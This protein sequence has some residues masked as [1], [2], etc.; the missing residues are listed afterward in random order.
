M[1]YIFDIEV[2]QIW[3]LWNVNGDLIISAHML[4]DINTSSRDVP[5]HEKIIVFI[6]FLFIYLHSMNPH[7]VR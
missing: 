1:T 2:E 7:K 6:Y 3:S 5:E 4:L